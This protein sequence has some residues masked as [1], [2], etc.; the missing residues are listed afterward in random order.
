MRSR[1]VMSGN[2]VVFDA[3]NLFEPRTD[4]VLLEMRRGPLSYTT[5]EGVKF[6]SKHPYQW[7]SVEEAELLLKSTS[8]EF[9][10]A[11]ID[12]L[13]DYYSYD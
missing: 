2:T 3:K 8:P 11:T 1:R 9:K 5:D 12:D 13:E 10:I 4:E 7:V 6:W